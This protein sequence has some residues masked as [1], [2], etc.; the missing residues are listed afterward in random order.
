MTDKEINKSK[1]SEKE[2]SKQFVHDENQEASL[3]KKD[4]ISEE[5]YLSPFHSFKNRSIPFE[6]LFHQK[7]VFG[8]YQKEA[9]MAQMFTF[10]ALDGLNNKLNNGYII[11]LKNKTLIEDIINLYNFLSI[12]N[13]NNMN[14]SDQ[15]FK[16]LPIFLKIMIINF[17]EK[18][19]KTPNFWTISFI[20]ELSIHEVADIFNVKLTNQSLKLNQLVMEPYILLIEAALRE[21]DSKNKRYKT[22]IFSYLVQA[23]GLIS[24]LTQIK[25][26]IIH[27]LSGFIDVFPKSEQYIIHALVNINLGNFC[28]GLEKLTKMV[29]NSPGNNF[30][31][32]IVEII[33]NSK[34]FLLPNTLSPIPIPIVTFF[35]TL[36]L[37]LIFNHFVFEDYNL[38]YPINNFD[39]V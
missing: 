35:P 30:F 9:L 37:P 12:V 28:S 39:D 32:K 38:D 24:Y 3:E 17:S 33:K 6:V 15:V 11:N 29:F 8:L 4:I 13:L 21:L 20:P 19:E 2:C 36:N 10:E 7:V 22:K 34:V 31:K 23:H 14:I 16:K 18:E 26:P 1:H 27:D 5:D 25:S